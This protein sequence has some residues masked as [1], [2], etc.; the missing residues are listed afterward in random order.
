MSKSTSKKTLP[1]S[2]PFKFTRPDEITPETL[3]RVL[4]WITVSLQDA[5]KEFKLADDRLKALE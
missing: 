5:E 1:V 2:P 4:E 3:N